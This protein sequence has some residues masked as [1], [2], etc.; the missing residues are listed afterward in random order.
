MSFGAS[1]IVATCI[2]TEEKRK[3][4]NERTEKKRKEQKET[5]VYAYVRPS[6]SRGPP[7]PLRL[8]RATM[9]ADKAWIHNSS[10]SFQPRG[11]RVHS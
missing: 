11:H 3:K 5:R 1:F 9:H 6:L 7:C 8:D 10:F 2:A 4:K